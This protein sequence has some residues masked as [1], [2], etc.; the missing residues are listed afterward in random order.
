MVISSPLEEEDIIEGLL[1]ENEDLSLEDMVF[2]KVCF[3]RVNEG[4]ETMFIFSGNQRE[5]GI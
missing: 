3:Y 5:E 2:F 1:K 4:A